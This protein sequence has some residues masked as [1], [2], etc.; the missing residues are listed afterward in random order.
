MCRVRINKRK[1]LICLVY[2]ITSQNSMNTPN[3]PP[4]A[5]G[6]W[7][8]ASHLAFAPAVVWAGGAV[9]CVVIL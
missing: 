7:H 8:V 1:Q 2:K 4:R 9:V 5:W 6:D 3:R